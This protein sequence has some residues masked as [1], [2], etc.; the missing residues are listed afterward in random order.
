LTE[1]LR[2]G[3]MEIKHEETSSEAACRQERARPEKRRCPLKLPLEGKIK[4]SDIRKLS[5]RFSRKRRRLG[6]ARPADGEIRSHGQAQTRCPAKRIRVRAQRLRQL[7]L[8]FGVPAAI[9]G[10]CLH[11]RRL[12]LYVTFPVDY[13]VARC[14][15]DCIGELTMS[16]VRHGILVLS[17]LLAGA[18]PLSA[19]SSAASTLS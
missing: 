14:H 5:G 18:W 10:S 11:D 13:P 1:R 9:S 19:R 6:L 12:R 7:S 4:R 17:V 16:L 8:R 2:V 15:R 3:Q